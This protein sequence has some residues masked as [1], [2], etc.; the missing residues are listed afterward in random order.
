[1][2]ASFARF[3]VSFGNRWEAIILTPA[4]DF[5]G[6]LKKTNQQIVAIIIALS[7]VELFLI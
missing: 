3:P 5:I 4:I 6:A 7:A 2:S 1:L